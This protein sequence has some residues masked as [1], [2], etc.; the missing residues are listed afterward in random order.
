MAARKTPH[1]LRHEVALS[2]PRALLPQPCQGLFFDLV[3]LVDV[4]PALGGLGLL[5][6]FRLLF[7]RRGSLCRSRSWRRR[8]GRGLLLRQAYFLASVAG[9]GIAAF[10]R[11]CFS[12]SLS[13]F[14]RILSSRYLG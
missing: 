13:S 14:V 10:F 9:V 2:A 3:Q 8:L 7:L 11:S 6:L 12:F 4:Y 1:V 5:L